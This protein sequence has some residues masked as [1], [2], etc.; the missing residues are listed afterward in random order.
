[1]GVFVGKGAS[2]GKGVSVD[3]GVSVGG[4]GVGTGAHALTSRTVSVTSAKIAKTDFFMTDSPFD[5]ITQEV[6]QRQVLLVC[7]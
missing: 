4:T 2:V 6:A 5:L 7:T 1:M 3:N